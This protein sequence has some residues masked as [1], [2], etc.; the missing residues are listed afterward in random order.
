MTDCTRCGKTV[1]GHDCTVCDDCAIRHGI[2]TRCG[3]TIAWRDGKV[4]DGC[5]REHDICTDCGR[6]WDGSDIT[7]SLVCDGCA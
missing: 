6:D 3:K 4:C 2:C 5:A 1:T 7:G